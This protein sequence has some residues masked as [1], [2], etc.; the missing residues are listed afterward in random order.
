MDGGLRVRAG[1]CIAVSSDGEWE[2]QVMKKGLEKGLG[3]KGKGT[4][5]MI[6]RGK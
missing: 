4:G 6:G 3:G 5:R 1:P 2:G